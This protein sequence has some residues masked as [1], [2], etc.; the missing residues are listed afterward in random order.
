VEDALGRVYREGRT[1]T[2]DV[3]GKATTAEFTQ[4]ILRAMEKPAQVKA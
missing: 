3:G 1:L 4:A 2:A